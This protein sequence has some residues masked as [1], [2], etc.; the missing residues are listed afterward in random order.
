MKGHK[1]ELNLMFYTINIE[2]CIP[3]NHPIR[4]IKK[5]ADD[6]LGKMKHS[7][8]TMYSSTGRPS[9]PPETLLKGC[10]LM[11]LHS[12]RSERLFCETL[13]WNMM[14]QWFL[15]WSPEQ[16]P[17]NHSTFSQNRDRLLEHENAKRFFEEILKIAKGKELLSEEHFSVDG[18]LIEAWASQKSF[19]PKDKGDSTN[20]KSSGEGHDGKNSWKDFSGKKRS[21]ET[22]QSTTDP[23]ARMMRKGKGQEAKLSYGANVLMENR[24]GLC[25]DISIDEAGNR[26]ERDGA[27][28]M[29][30]NQRKK[31]AIKT[32][33]ADKG[34]HTSDFVEFLRKKKI[35]PHIAVK[36][37]WR[38]EGLD[39]RTTRTKG[40]EISQVIR[41]RIEEINGWMKTIGFFRKT[42]YV[43]KKYN[44]HWAY[45]TCLTYNLVRMANLCE[46]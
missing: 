39:G 20:D 19:K 23:E 41:K 28:K 18:T 44:Q 25:V 24:N 42:R 10:L 14:Y 16:K 21:N 11:I 36:E 8:N 32:V 40:Y 45:L 9:I 6:A 17:F 38:I 5:L 31:T 1:Q 37:K 30:N 26:S 27:E 33:G 4:K 35:H 43:G 22:H 3:Q 34:Y 7:F 46:N 29:I 2:E 13:G 15:D 12:V